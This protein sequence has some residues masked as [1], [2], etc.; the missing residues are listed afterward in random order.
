[1]MLIRY[2]R[3]YLGGEIEENLAISS[4]GHFLATIMTNNGEHYISQ[5]I[6]DKKYII[7]YLK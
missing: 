4:Q 1:M 2:T 7:T 3:F 5:R 6:E